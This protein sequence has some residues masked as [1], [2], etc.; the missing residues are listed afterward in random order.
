MSDS[1]TELTNRQKRLLIDLNEMN[2]LVRVNG[3]TSETMQGLIDESLVVVAGGFY[4]LTSYGI[5]EAMIT[6]R[7]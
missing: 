4:R 7:R 5:R 6:K 2:G 3:K 1:K